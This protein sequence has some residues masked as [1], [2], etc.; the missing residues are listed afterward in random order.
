MPFLNLI[1]LLVETYMTLTSLLNNCLSFTKMI[2]LIIY[3]DLAFEL[4]R[5][6]LQLKIPSLKLLTPF[7][8]SSRVCVSLTPTF[9][10]T[11]PFSTIPNS[12]LLS[13]ENNLVHL[14][15]QSM[16]LLSQCTQKIKFKISFY[17]TGLPSLEANICT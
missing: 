1:Y 10:F 13:Y 16:N 15:F 11:C 7:T 14:Q 2:F 3:Q 8:T 6:L 17:V 9:L 12:S 5:I 4:N